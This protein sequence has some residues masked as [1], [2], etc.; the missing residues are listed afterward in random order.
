MHS[1]D[2]CHGFFCHQVKLKYRARLAQSVEREI[3]NVDQGRGFE[4]HVER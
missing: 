3:R 4:H 2:F 1:F